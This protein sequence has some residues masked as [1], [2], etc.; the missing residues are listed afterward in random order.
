[1]ASSGSDAAF[2]SLIT[3]FQIQ[4]ALHE[5]RRELDHRPSWIE[6]P[7]R[8]LL[9]LVGSYTDSSSKLSVV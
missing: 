6:V 8:A 5:L 3:L 4:C 1:M 7:I 2:A 9:S